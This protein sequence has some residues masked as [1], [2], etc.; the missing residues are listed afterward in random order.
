MLAPASLL[1]P[2]IPFEQWSLMEE[3]GAKMATRPRGVR[4]PAQAAPLRSSIRRSQDRS[5]IEKQ[6]HEESVVQKGD[7]DAAEKR[8]LQGG[9]ALCD[10]FEQEKEAGPG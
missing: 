9:D 2:M 7:D 4:F 1:S 6:R 10:I 3:S 5:E 8:D